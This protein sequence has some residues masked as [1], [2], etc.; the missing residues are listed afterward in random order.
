MN[1][2]SWL[3]DSGMAGIAPKVCVPFNPI[4]LTSST[5]V[6]QPCQAPGAVEAKRYQA[7]QRG[8]AMCWGREDVSVMGLV[9]KGAVWCV[10]LLFLWDLRGVSF[11][12]G[13]Q[14][15]RYRRGKQQGF[16]VCL[17]QKSPKACERKIVA[18]TVATSRLLSWIPAAIL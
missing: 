3:W 18:N 10:V 11:Q 2:L 1:P 5:S 8:S 14:E 7:G 12:R 13:L 6:S 9:V 17:W 16:H 15:L 4:S